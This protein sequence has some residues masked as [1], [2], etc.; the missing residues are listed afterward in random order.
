MLLLPD[1]SQAAGRTVHST[2][3][4]LLLLLLPL[5]KEIHSAKHLLLLPQPLPVHRQ[6]H[7]A[8][9]LPLGPMQIQEHPGQHMLLLSD[10]RQGKRACGF[11]LTRSRMWTGCCTMQLE[12]MPRAAEHCLGP[13]TPCFLLPCQ[14]R[15]LLP[16]LPCHLTQWLR[17]LQQLLCP[18]QQLL[19]HLQELPR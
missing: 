9:H 18:L 11:Q 12:L 3:H 2:R 14:L 1:T 10:Y 7:S 4:V 8:S 19:C 13:H 6:E 15:P 17:Q 16:Q 5:H